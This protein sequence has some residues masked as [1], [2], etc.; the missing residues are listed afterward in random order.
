MITS[1]YLKSSPPNYNAAFDI[2]ASGAQALFGAGQ[3]GSGGDL[4]LYLLDAYK[5][6]ELK[7][8]TASKGRLLS[9]LR[10]FPE[11]EPTMKRYVSE[12]VG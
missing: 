10:A 5:Q 7:P 9:L 12:M 8:D 3:G 11:E 2:L 6:A 4:C 1:R